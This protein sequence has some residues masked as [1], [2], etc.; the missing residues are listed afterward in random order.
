MKLGMDRI[1]S[2]WPAAVVAGT[3]ADG[4]RVKG[5]MVLLIK[6]PGFFCEKQGSF[7]DLSGRILANVK[8]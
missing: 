3:V 8:N 7:R 6:D 4:C 2:I 5:A 1:I